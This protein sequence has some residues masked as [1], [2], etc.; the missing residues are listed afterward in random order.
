MPLICGNAKGISTDKG[1]LGPKPKFPDAANN[2]PYFVAASRETVVAFFFG[3]GMWQKF[4]EMSYI[5]P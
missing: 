1:Q 2:G 3:A 4:A 5:I